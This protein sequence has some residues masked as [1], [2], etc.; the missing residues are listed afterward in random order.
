MPAEK[1]SKHSFIRFP[2][3]NNKRLREGGHKK[4]NFTDKDN[5][6]PI[7][8]TCVASKI[9]ELLILKRCDQFLI[10]SDNQFGFKK[11]HSTDMSVFVLKQVLDYYLHSSSPVYICFLDASKAFDKINH[12][13][14]FSKLLKRNMPVIFV[15]LLAIWYSTQSFI[16]RWNNCVSLP[17]TVTNGVRQGGILS[18][19]LFNV[20]MDELSY[21]LNLQSFGCKINNVCFNHMFY[22]D[23]SVLL[24]PSPHALQKLVTLC[25]VFA[26]SNDIMY[27]TKKSFVMCCKP[28]HMKNLTVPLC[29]L[30]GCALKYAETHKYLG[31][32]LNEYCNDDK[33][34]LRQRKG[35]YARGNV[36][37][38]RF[39]HC[40]PDVKA[41]L[42]K[43]YCSTLYC[44]QLWCNYTKS[45]YN[46]LK[47][48]YNK[49]YRHL[50]KAD[51]YSSISNLMVMN[52]VDSM[53]CLWR[54]NIFSF[55]K[56]VI[57]SSNLLVSTITSTYFYCN[58]SKL[59]KKWHSLLSVPKV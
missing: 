40:S 51:T 22:A 48:A 53:C 1:T 47:R 18:P 32:F 41:Q 46:S 7:A 52:N 4:G 16:V 3:F 45:T 14:L 43:S 6:R 15:R 9:L 11:K 35:I 33:D 42:F 37:I 20:Y 8:I 54:K 26:I 57:K 23:D 50:M 34:I 13:N 19:I 17:F 5:Y 59:V 28:K 25:E 58:D 24:A 21:I 31:V 2:C 30:N 55:V 10:T 38:S 12:W 49:V 56:R 36:L 44:S 39:K 29:Y 27:N